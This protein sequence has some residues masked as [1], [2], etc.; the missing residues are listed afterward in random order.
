VAGLAR[1]HARDGY[2]VRWPAD[3]AGWLRGLDTMAAWVA[4]DATGVVGHAVLRPVTDDRPEA[5]AWTAATGRRADG[6]GLVA[7]LF[8]DP[9]ARGGGHGRR[10]LDAAVDEA[11]RRSLWP[12]LDVMA[13]NTAATAVYEH[14]G[15][16]RVASRDFEFPDGLR[17]PMHCYVA[18]PPPEPDRR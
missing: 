9:A 17:L 11:R 12:V 5:P 1:C 15:W 13:V 2:P 16:R 3:P 14:L 4:T 10:L 6:L 18:P 8:V 7:R